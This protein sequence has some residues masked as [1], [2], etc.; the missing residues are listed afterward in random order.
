MSDPQTTRQTW[1]PDAAR[2][3]RGEC[4]W[5]RC[6]CPDNGPTDA[7]VQAPARKGDEAA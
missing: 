1:C 5:P 2:Y 6:G 7:E 3:D 4:G